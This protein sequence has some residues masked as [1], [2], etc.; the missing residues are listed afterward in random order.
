MATPAFVLLTCGL[1]TACSQET[2]NSDQK[3][4]AQHIDIPQ[5]VEKKPEYHE[6]RSPMQGPNLANTFSSSKSSDEDTGKSKEDSA[7]TQTTTGAKAARADSSQTDSAAQQTFS[8][9]NSATP[10]NTV[11]DSGRTIEDKREISDITAIENNSVANVNMETGQHPKLIIKADANIAPLIKTTISGGTLTVFSSQPFN[12]KKTPAVTLVSSH[13]NSVQLGG[14]GN[15]TAS[16][17]SEEKVQ[18]IVNGSGNATLSGIVRDLQVIV[19]GAG[20]ALLSGLMAE[21]AKAEINGSGSAK[22]F[23]TDNLSAT[24]NGSGNI[25]YKGDPELRQR[26]NGSG[27]VSRQ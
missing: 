19:A 1:L 13:L 20:S 21:N 26:V 23:C 7:S 17:L 15:V 22:L 10:A 12:T 8:T 25:T 24:I 4:A 3:P 16:G 2:T 27:A 18:V 11:V 9:N 5:R 6:V 14:S